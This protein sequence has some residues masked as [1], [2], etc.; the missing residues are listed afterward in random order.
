MEQQIIQL[1]YE[2]W[3]AAFHRDAKAFQHLVRPDAVMICGGYQCS[4]REYA[5]MIPDFYISGYSIDGM[6][7]ISSGID[8]VILH[9]VLRVDVDQK[10][11]KDLEG[12]FHVVSVWK[13]IG[14]SWKLAF[15]MDSRII[16]Q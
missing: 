9:Y 8:E 1:E 6:E 10:S 11:H 4:G 7:V 13:R 2:M 15:N 12:V 3:E 16:E 5:G 14:E